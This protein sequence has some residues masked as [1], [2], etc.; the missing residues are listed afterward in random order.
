MKTELQSKH[1]Q[2]KKIK[3]ELRR[4]NITIKSSLSVIFYNCSIHQVNIASK[5]KLKAITKRHLRKYDKLCRKTSTP[6]NEK[7]TFGHIRNTVLYF[8]NY[9]LSNKE[10]NTLPFGLDLTSLLIHLLIH[11]VFICSQN[12]NL[13]IT[14][15]KK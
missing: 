15:M 5:S 11:S 1:N 4:V 13:K 3:K 2:K 7:V 8:S 14:K 10:F 12:I 9:S 6:I